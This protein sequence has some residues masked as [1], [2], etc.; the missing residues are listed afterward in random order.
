M[1]GERARWFLYHDRR[2]DTRAERRAGELLAVMKKSKERRGL[3]G[4]QKSK[5]G[6]TS[7]KL[8]EVGISYDQSAQ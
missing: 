3:G 2:R 6:S 8:E 4:D 5:S 1:T 7:L